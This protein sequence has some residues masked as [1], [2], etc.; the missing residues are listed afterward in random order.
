[1]KEIRMA[2]RR[3]RSSWGFTL[4]ELLVVIAIIA[5]L[6]AIL[7]PV[8]ARAR[9]AAR[10][11]SCTSNM[12]QLGTAFALYLSDYDQRFPMAGWWD[13]GTYQAKE[14]AG[15]W[16][17]AIYPYVKNAKAYTCPSSSDFQVEPQD[18]NHTATDYIMN[19]NINGGRAGGTESNIAAPADCVE[20]IEGHQDWDS[21]QN[22]ICVTPFS[23]GA[24]TGVKDIWCRE[25]STWGNQSSFITSGLWA[26][27]TRVW[28]QPR[29]NGT[30]NVLFTDGHVKSANIGVD[31][32]IGAQQSVNRMKAVLP[33]A[34]NMCPRQD[35]CNDWTGIF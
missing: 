16:N 11:T 2:A 13:T 22:G 1:M 34:K 17:D 7:F 10:K 21:G 26:T 25:Y 14:G 29:H 5:I 9:E 6:A 20:L 28:G 15:E 24:L 35:N 12:K 3:V 8:F 32:V 33:F 30:V 19:N 31:K 18:W 27:D 23:N 4:I